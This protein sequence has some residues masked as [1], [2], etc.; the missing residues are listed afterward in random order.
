[1]IITPNFDGV[2]GF[3]DTD[4]LKLIAVR[5]PKY[6][7][8]QL[9]FSG[10]G[11]SMNLAFASIRLHSNDRLVD[12]MAVMDDAGKLGDEIAKRWNANAPTEPALEV[13]HQLQDCAGLVGLPSGASHSQIISAIRV[14]LTE[15][16]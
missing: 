14:K 1:M 16:L 15:S 3:V 5:N 7:H 13:L 6:G 8:V 2:E 12:A 10:E 9:A 4:T 11:K